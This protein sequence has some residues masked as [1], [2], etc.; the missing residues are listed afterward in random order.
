MLRRLAFATGP[1]EIVSRLSGAVTAFSNVVNQFHTGQAAMGGDCCGVDKGVAAM[2]VEDVNGVTEGTTT[3]SN[4]AFV[5]E[6]QPFYAKRIELFEK[7][8]KREQDRLEAAKAAGVKIKV[9][10]PDGTEKEAVK[11]ATTPMDIARGISSGLAKKVV[12]AYVDDKEWDIN[13]P[14][15]GDCAL[16][17]FSP[18]DEEGMDV[19]SHRPS[20]H[21]RRA[22]HSSSFTEFVSS[23]SL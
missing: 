3:K 8:L 1:V 22:I 15:V 6:K 12:S 14:L 2:T 7:Y 11:G 20:Q 9:V 17:L 16:K 13:R 23:A 18:N 5:A 19:R 21:L 4:E 10:L